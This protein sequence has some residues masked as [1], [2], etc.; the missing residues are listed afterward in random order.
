VRRSRA[1][2]LVLGVAVT[3]MVLG[4]CA[5]APGSGDDPDPTARSPEEPADTDAGAGAPPETEGG[6]E[7]EPE[8]EPEPESP[9]GDAPEAR[10][11][12]ELPDGLVLARE[13]VAE[14]PEQVTALAVRAGDERIFAG[15]KQGTIWVV[16]DDE[17][18]SE[19][20]LDL[21][22]QVLGTGQTS[23]QG[24]LSLAF[25]PF[26]PDRMFVYYVV[27]G[28]G[29]TRVSEFRVDAAGDRADPGSERTVLEV[30]QPFRW[31]NGGHLLF[32][33]D[34]LLW[35]SL[36]DGGIRGDPDLVAQDPFELLGSVIRIDVDG[37]D[38]Y[39]IPDDNPFADGTEGAPEVFAIG[40]RNPWRMAFDPVE[41][42]LFVTDVGQ[43]I[44]EWVNLVEHDGGGVNFGWPIREGSTCFAPH[45]DLCPGEGLTDPILE[46]GRVN[47]CA[48][49]GGQVYDGR[50]L[51]ALAGHF[52]YTDFCAGWLRSFRYHDG[53]VRDE[54]DWSDELEAF[55]HPVTVS[56]D[57]DGELLVSD[58]LGAIWR[59][60]PG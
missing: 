20:F 60:V 27:E 26:D 3:A 18:R 35:L 19:P 29:R 52:F 38:P 36:G 5:E 28:D 16:E 55:D 22:E 24:F 34:E 46:Y 37:D 32:G 17:L 56:S 41:W 40:L 31:H 51:P 2:R 11:Y 45:G 54:R 59:I 44:Y 53:E 25:H 43:N 58:D 14:A 50:A 6:N 8:P 7:P 49:I 42:R 4:A 48:I 30:A 57:A 12:E 10:P 21:S 13:L 33:P 39:A 23:E 47:E 15:D 9:F 1:R